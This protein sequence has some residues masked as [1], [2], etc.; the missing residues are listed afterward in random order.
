MPTR[1]V[2]AFARNLGLRLATALVLLPP[3][4]LALVRGGWG[5][6]L[7]IG[8]ACAVATWEYYR[9]V[10]LRRGAEQA[11][12]LC[13]AF[14]L[15]LLPT[16]L[17]AHSGEAALWLVGALAALGWVVQLLR[18]EVGGAPARVGLLTSG[19]LFS[20]VGLLAVSRLR[21]GPEGLSWTGCLLLG[22]WGNDALA[23]LGGHLLGRTPLA[24]R[25]SPGKTW[26][27]W[28][29]GA[30][31]SL[32]AT[33]AARATFFGALRPGDCLALGLLMATAGPLGDLSKSVLKRAGGAKDSGRLLPGHGG[34]LDRIDALLFNAPLVLAY[35]TWLGQRG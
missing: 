4:L 12:G 34:V 11:L 28:G 2:S 1:T 13:A 27:G 19:L 23:Y 22:T 32:L 7:V 30:A 10:S 20:G 31:G 6:A 16:A 35:A 21:A 26:E 14:A 8:A 18:G 3:L 17:P 15:P 29:C 25:V 33:L 24:P 9:L 5:C